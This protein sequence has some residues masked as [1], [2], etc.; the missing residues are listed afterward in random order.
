LTCRLSYLLV[1]MVNGG[2]L[3]DPA[4]Q[5]GSAWLDAGYPGARPGDNGA[6]ERAAGADTD[7]AAL[8]GR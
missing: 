5:P 4:L 1:R 8:N 3:S 2:L 7:A 6:Q